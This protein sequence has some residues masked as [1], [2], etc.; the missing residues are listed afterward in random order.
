MTAKPMAWIEHHKG[1][2]NLNWEQS[3]PDDTPLYAS[4]P[5]QA[6]ALAIAEA[7]RVCEQEAATFTIHNCT[8]PE[9][10]KRGAQLCADRVRALSPAPSVTEEWVQEQVR[11]ALGNAVNYPRHDWCMYQ[12]GFRAALQSLGYEVTP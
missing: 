2:D 1:G 5:A 8:F 6:R 9:S 10:Y 11:K 3:R 4:S 12:D 7:A